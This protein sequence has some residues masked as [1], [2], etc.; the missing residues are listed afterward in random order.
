MSR[1]L[2]LGA[3]CVVIGLLVFTV[4]R[5][6]EAAER[7][8][9]STNDVSLSVRVAD[10]PMERMRGLSGYTAD[11]VKAQGMLFVFPEAEVREFWMK[12]MKLDLDVLWIRDGQIVS[13]DKG[14]KAPVAGAE[15]ERMTSAP[16]PVDMVLELP[17]GYADKF[18]LN[19][20]SPIKIELP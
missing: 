11:S 6:R 15:P 9:V 4:L 17:A 19:P 1:A 3:V 2:I 14:V 10:A 16:L 7:A 18:D 8:T 5:G 20:G 12:G 13:V